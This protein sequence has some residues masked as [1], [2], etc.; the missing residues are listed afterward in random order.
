MSGPQRPRGGPKEGGAEQMGLEEGG[1]TRGVPKSQRVGCH[2]AEGCRGE[3]RREL[4]REVR[5]EMRR[6]V[7]REEAGGQGLSELL[8]QGQFGL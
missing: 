1:R 3:V 4:R 5:R 2:G 7:R 8:L 6:E